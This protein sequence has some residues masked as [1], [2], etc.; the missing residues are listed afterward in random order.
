METKTSWQ[1]SLWHSENMS[2]CRFGTSEQIMKQEDFITCSKRRRLNAGVIGEHTCLLGDGCRH[3][4]R[5]NT[6]ECTTTRNSQTYV[7]SINGKRKHFPN[8]FISP[9]GYSCLLPSFH[10]LDN[11]DHHKRQE[12]W[13]TSDTLTWLND[14]DFAD[15]LALLSRNHFQVQEKK[16]ARNGSQF[17]LI[18]STWRRQNWIWWRPTPLSNCQSQLVGGITGL[19]Y[20]QGRQ[21]SLCLL[22]H[23][24]PGWWGQSWIASILFRFDESW[25]LCGLM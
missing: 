4:I 6:E 13:N 22:G 25:G 1:T 20:C 24:L 12:Q 17:N 11:E 15:D 16:L 3:D 2:D 7:L 10:W 14:L 9:R 18:R 23:S 5:R 21:T 19:L 8:K